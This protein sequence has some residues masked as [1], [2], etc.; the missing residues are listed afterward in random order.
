MTRAAARAAA[1][2]GRRELELALL[3][4]PVLDQGPALAGAV[5]CHLDLGVLAEH[6]PDPRR[7]RARSGDRDLAAHRPLTGQHRLHS[8]RTE[9]EAGHLDPLGDR[10]PRRPRPGG[11]VAH[12]AHRVRPAAAALV[13]HRRGLGLPVGPGPGE[14]LATALGTDDELGLIADP[15]VLVVDRDQ[16]VDLGLRDRRQVADLAKTER[17]GLGLE[18]LDRVADDIGDRGRAE[19][20]R[21]IPPATPEAPAPTLSFS[22]TSTSAPRSASLQAVERPSTPPPTTT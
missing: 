7:P 17:L 8:I 20:L 22:S 3:C 12:G 19:K 21:T 5:D 15:L 2:A 6:R 11:E 14:V 18:D 16:V 9:L 10:R 4:L 13:Q 1:R